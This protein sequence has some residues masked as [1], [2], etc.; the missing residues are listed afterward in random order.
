MSHFLQI[1]SSDSQEP[2]REN[3]TCPEV[4]FHSVK[5]RALR[6]ALPL[7][8]SVLTVTAKKSLLSHEITVSLGALPHGQGGIL[9]QVW[10]L[11][12]VVPERISFFFPIPVRAAEKCLA[13]EIPISLC[14]K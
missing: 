9:S 5:P 8:C 11:G 14:L 4:I 2:F 6:S 7:P 13:L 10:V 12:T 3:Q 1:V